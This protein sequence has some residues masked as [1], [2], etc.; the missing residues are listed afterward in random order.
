[1]KNLRQFTINFLLLIS[2]LCSCNQ[3]GIN[4]QANLLLG[5]LTCEYL[6]N[7][8]GIETQTP[9][10][11]WEITSKVNG[12]FQTAYRIIVS[13]SEISIK[14][15]KGNIWDSGKIESANSNNINYKGLELYPAKRYWWKVKWWNSK[16]VEQNWSEVEWFETGLFSKTDWKEANWIGLAKDSR[17]DEFKSRPLKNKVMEQPQMETSH[18]APLFRKEFS[19]S[20]KIKNARIYLSGLGYNELYI[21]GEKVGD[22]VLNPGQTS[23]DKRAFYDIYDVTS[24]ITNGKNI[25][26]VMLGNGFYGQNM[27]FGVKF[28]DY[29]K[30]V[31]KCLVKIN[32]EDGSDDNIVTDESWL[33]S[34]GPIVFDN[35]YAGETYDAREEVKNWCNVEG[36][37]SGWEKSEIMNDIE[38]P[39]LTAQMIQP[40]KKIKYISAVDFLKS[41]T[42]K[43]IYDLGQNI[44]GWAKIK[45]NEPAGTKITIRYSEILTEDKQELETAT[46]GGWGQ[47]TGFDQ[48]D[49]YICKG[50]GEEIWEPRFTYHGFR[51]MEIEGISNPDIHSVEACFVRSSVERVG[52][53]NCS[54]EII[55]RIYST[56]I[57]TIE[58]NLHSVPEDCPHREK[59][60]WLG[61][62]HASVETMNFNFDMRRFWIKFM[63]DVATNLGQGSVTYEQIPATVGIPTNIAVGKRVCQEARPDWGSAIILIP[64][65]NYLFYNNEKILEE[66]YPYMVQWMAYLKNYLQDNI[67]YQGYGDWCHPDW[68]GGEKIPTPTALTSTA[69]YHYTLNLLAKISMLLEKPNNAKSYLDEAELI[70]SAFNQKFFNKELK[71]YGTQTANAVALDMGLVPVDL[72]KEVAKSLAELELTQKKGGHFYTGIHGAKRMFKELSDFGYENELFE[73]LG[74]DDFPS[75]KYLFN[76]GFTTWPEAFYNYDKEICSIKKGSHNHPMQ[77][78]FAVWFHQNVGGIQ[79]DESLPGFKHFIIKPFGFHHLEFANASYKSIYGMI[80]SE[81]KVQQNQFINSVEIPVNTSVTVFVPTSDPGSVKIEEK[82]LGSEMDIE[83][84]GIEKGYA[85]YSLKSGLY[86]IKSNI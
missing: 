28:L 13:D 54:D 11:S 18:P 49:I 30:P 60:A 74:K 48:T 79:P 6:Q 83:F 85:K 20:K 58:D 50:T 51:F 67:L 5:N 31:L 17:S 68:K 46:T 43:Y 10:F 24:S 61:D 32:Y 4:L 75:F 19:V 71:T 33:S 69:Y 29:G 56:S 77:S 63:D 52:N 26:G 3:K 40:I 41:K 39:V 36:D 73:M 80:S 1:M 84:L 15:E 44:S 45:V 14:N 37:V 78:G 38:I 82:Q 53:F 16:G 7:P 72:E 65:N 55:N 86:L 23:Y 42:G 22:A 57:W 59:C 64:W 35:V 12:E 8:M 2:V 21:N 76:H 25:I 81:W 34:C 9:R 47:A 27:A 70:K 66:N 62:A